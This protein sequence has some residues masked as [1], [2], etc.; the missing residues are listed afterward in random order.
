MIIQKIT[1][2][3]VIQ[4]FNTDTQ[5]FVSQ[6][7]VAG[8]EVD[9]EVEGSAINQVDFENKL[10]SHNGYLPFTMVQPGEM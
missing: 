10:V 2:G 8:D 5:K 1:T 3:F 9:Y 7:F 6:Q 4:E